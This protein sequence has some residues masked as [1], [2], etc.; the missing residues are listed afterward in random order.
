MNF[1]RESYLNMQKQIER[2]ANFYKVRKF[3]PSEFKCIESD[4]LAV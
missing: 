1:F 2:K 3:S 4:L